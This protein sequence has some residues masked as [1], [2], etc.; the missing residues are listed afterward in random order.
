M[1]SS[2]S[3]ANETSDAR[4]K[5]VD[6][7]LD[8]NERSSANDQVVISFCLNHIIDQPP[9]RRNESFQQSSH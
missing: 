5:A 9:G 7:L 4:W 2:A 3:R 1:S 6:F 8:L